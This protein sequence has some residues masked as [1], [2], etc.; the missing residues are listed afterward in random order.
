MKRFVIL[1]LLI[2]FL[3]SVCLAK[4]LPLSLTELAN[5]SDIIVVGVLTD[6]TEFFKRGVD[7]SQGVIAVEE[8]IWGKAD[9]GT[10]LILKW[11]NP[12]DLS[13]PRVD[14]CNDQNKKIIWFLKYEGSNIV[15]SDHCSRAVSLEK[16]EEILG[17]LKSLKSTK[18]L[19]RV[20]EDK[21]R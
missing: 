7:Y 11:K 16:K 4:F 21:N 2:F 13:C 15:I 1:L 12:F 8:I 18:N 10:K 5:N 3:P 20:G 14:H 17:I 6:V 9:I 19:H